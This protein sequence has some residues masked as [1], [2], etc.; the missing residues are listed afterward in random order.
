MI[1]WL[2]HPAHLFN[3]ASDTRR[4]ATVIVLSE[5]DIKPATASDSPWIYLQCR[6]YSAIE[7]ITGS[8]ADISPF[9]ARP[10]RTRGA[11]P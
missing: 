11:S 4:S 5:P 1:G 7:L 10:T 8:P 2:N 9:T 3:K 6:A